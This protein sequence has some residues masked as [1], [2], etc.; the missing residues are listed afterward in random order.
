MG[1]SSALSPAQLPV[2]PPIRTEIRPIDSDRDFFGGARSRALRL[3]PS[4]VSIRSRRPSCPCLASTEA[5]ARYR[6]ARTRNKSAEWAG[7]HGTGTRRRRRG[8][9]VHVAMDAARRGGR[10]VKDAGKSLHLS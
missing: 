2:S 8:G 10:S 3:A 6:A 9:P 5:S 1:G 7:L 4:P